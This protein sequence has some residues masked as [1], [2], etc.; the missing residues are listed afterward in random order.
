MSHPIQNRDRLHTQ[1]EAPHSGYSEFETPEQQAAE[2]YTAVRVH[3]TNPVETTTGGT[4]FGIYETTI[5]P[6]SGNQQILPHDPLRQYAYILAVDAPIVLTTTLEAAQAPVNQGQAAGTGQSEV[7]PS[8]PAAGATFT[9]TNTTGS[10][11]TLQSA[12]FKLVTDATVANRFI[13]V[14]ILDTAGNVVAEN[15]DFSAIVASTTITAWYA[16]GIPNTSNNAS[17]STLGGLPQVLIQPGWQVKINVTSMDAGDQLS[18]IAL[19]LSQAA[20]PGALPAGAYLP[21]GMFTPAIRH[22]DP[23]YAANTSSGPNRVV[24]LVERGRTE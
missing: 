7:I 17:G 18:N 24:M 10:P 13:S 23:V 8:N 15:T 5:I 12:T 6:G 20:T 9:Y 3:V 2:D 21:A 11:Q 16:Q 4:Q 19:V 14:Q 22:N 1:S